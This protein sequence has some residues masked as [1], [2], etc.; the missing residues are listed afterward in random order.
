M[1]STSV[2]QSQQL[3]YIW[4]FASNLSVK[5]EYC[6]MSLYIHFVHF[7]HFFHNIRITLCH[8]QLIYHWCQT[9]KK[10][11][12]HFPIMQKS[13]RSAMTQHTDNLDC[14][15]NN[16]ISCECAV[17]P[18]GVLTDEGGLSSRFYKKT[19]YFGAKDVEQRSTSLWLL[20]YTSLFPIL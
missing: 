3:Q 17:Y 12:L 1:S 4:V 6:P 13:S 16:L 15:C 11:Q 18:R 7:I 5:T 20:N 2:G 14:Y 10:L 19:I 8:R 9:K